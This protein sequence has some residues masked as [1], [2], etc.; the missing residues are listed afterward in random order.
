MT[1]VKVSFRTWSAS[2]LRRGFTLTELL[3]VIIIIAI[4][5]AMTMTV[6]RS[7]M[8]STRRERTIATI[9]KIDAA[10]TSA[11]EKY[12][13]RKPDVSYFIGETEDLLSRSARGGE[14]FRAMAPSERRLTVYHW[15]LVRLRRPPWL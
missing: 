15:V 5:A 6:Q 11:Y 12:Q 7:A 14:A 10:L 2:S 3:L 4:L 13:Y 8:Q 1:G 9:R